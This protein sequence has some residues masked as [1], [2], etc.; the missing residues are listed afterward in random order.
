MVMK[1]VSSEG[2][3]SNP[4][5]KPTA[6]LRHD[7]RHTSFA[8]HWPSKCDV[9]GLNVSQT[10]Y[11]EVTEKIIDAVQEGRSL[12][13]DFVSVDPLVQSVRSESLR[14]KI[15]SFEIVCPDGH[16]VRVAMNVLH[17]ARQM[18]RVCGPDTTTC[19]LSRASELGIPVFFYG[20]TDAVL[21]GIMA[22]IERRFGDLI[23]AGTYSPPFRP[24]S[25]TEKAGVIEMINTSGARMTFVGLGAP[26]QSEFAFEFRDKIHGALLCTGA[27]FEFL[28]GTK[29]RAPNWMQ[30]YGIEWFYRLLQEPRRLLYRYTVNNVVYLRLL[31]TAIIK[32][33]LNAV[34][35]G[36]LSFRRPT[37]LDA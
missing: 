32:K 15:N 11:A 34:T 10:S 22:T 27:A 18:D 23:V 29:R 4:S 35:E 37:D 19:L 21:A 7:P 24:L 1:G 3:R 12:V 16:P 20:S 25:A 5:F 28:A 17:D 36:R 8:A 26:R 9:F 14:E 2:S 31:I 30:R 13:V 33:H 6:A